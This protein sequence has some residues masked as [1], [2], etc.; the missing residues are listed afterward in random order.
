MKT[1][2]LKFSQILLSLAC[3][4]AVACQS[5]RCAKQN[6]PS[7]QEASLT[8]I[9]QKP[10]NQ[11]VD[12]VK[13]YKYDGTLQCDMGKLIPP[14]AME[15]ELAGIQVFSKESKS[16]GMMRIQVCGSPTGQANVFEIDRKDLEAAKKIGFQ[17]WTFD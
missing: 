9:N 4:A 16:D 14:D 1:T 13:V 15:K 2:P 8:D 11:V 12:R 7:S 3:L 6:A 5:G 17:E 10:I